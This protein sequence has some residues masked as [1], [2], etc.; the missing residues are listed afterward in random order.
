MGENGELGDFYIEY[1]TNGSKGQHNL[2]DKK[3][4]KSLV[5]LNHFVN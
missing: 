3:K 4:R 2:C 1:S 5:E